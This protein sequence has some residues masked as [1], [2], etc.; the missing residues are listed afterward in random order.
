M[1]VLQEPGGVCDMFSSLWGTQVSTS[2]LSPCRPVQGRGG[3]GPCVANPSSY[4]LCDLRQVLRLCD[5]SASASRNG[6]D[7]SSD[8]EIAGSTHRVHVPGTR[9]RFINIR[10]YRYARV[11][12]WF[13]TPLGPTSRR[14]P[15]IKAVNVS[16]PVLS[17]P[18]CRH[19]PGPLKLEDRLGALREGLTPRP[20]CF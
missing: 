16:G 13:S 17:L 3:A 20:G 1:S 12:G 19:A 6:D 10:C 14:C 5:P 15:K 7:D 9:T 4:Q 2:A 18:R 11:G 8:L